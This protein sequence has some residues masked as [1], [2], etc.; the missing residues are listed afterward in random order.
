MLAVVVVVIVICGGKP[1]VMIAVGVVVFLG[2]P[3][4]V[5]GDFDGFAVSLL[6]GL[7]KG[8]GNKGALM[9]DQDESCNHQRLFDPFQGLS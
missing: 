6:K 3:A 4:C 2:I 5:C 8:V 9:S 7:A 1:S